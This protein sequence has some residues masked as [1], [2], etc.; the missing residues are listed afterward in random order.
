MYPDVKRQGVTAERRK[1]TLQRQDDP[2]GLLNRLKVTASIDGKH[3]Y[4]TVYGSLLAREARSRPHKCPNDFDAFW[5]EAPGQ[6]PRALGSTRHLTPHAPC[7]TARPKTW[8]VYEVSFVNDRPAAPH[9]R[10]PLRCPRKPGR[11][12]CCI[13]RVARRRRAPLRRRRVDSGA[14][15]PSRSHR[16]PRHAVLTLPQ[17]RLRRD[18]PRAGS[19]T[20][21]TATSNTP[22]RTTTSAW[23]WG[24][25][26]PSTTSPRC[27][28][29]TAH[30]LA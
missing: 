8:N 20:T 2:S 15:E 17:T 1:L 9:L 6:G 4:R 18:L 25:C 24:R 22:T 16:H 7:P 30:T 12:R 3:L 26:A 19:T 27:H 29:G 11:Y 10:H 14:W 21:G 23:W 13:A 5:G 28:N